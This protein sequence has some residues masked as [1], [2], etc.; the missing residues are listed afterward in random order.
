MTDSSCKEVP[1]VVATTVSRADHVI[2]F[3]EIRI[4]PQEEEKACII[5]SAISFDRLR[6][7]QNLRSIYN[8]PQQDIN[9]SLAPSWMLFSN[10]GALKL[11]EYCT[12]MN[13]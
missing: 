5:N 4:R 6:H 9:A 2:A 13:T 12:D 11:A 10:R 1:G 3:R 7:R 8:F